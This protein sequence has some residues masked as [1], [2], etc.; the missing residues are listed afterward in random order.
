VTFSITVCAIWAIVWTLA[1]VEHTRLVRELAHQVATAPEADATWALRQMAQLQEPPLENIVLA[2]ASPTRDV[3]RQAQDSLTELLHKWQH[4]SKSGRGAARV[5]RRLERLAI[6]LDAE[7]IALTQMDPQWFERTLETMLRLAGP[8]S[9]ADNGLAFTEQCESMLLAARST[10]A[11]PRS[12]VVPVA[13]AILQSAP[14]G[15]FAPPSRLALQTIVPTDGPA[16]LEEDDAPPAPP[17]FSPDASPMPRPFRHESGGSLDPPEPMPAA[18]APQEDRALSEPL[19]AADSRA[20]LEAWLNAKGPSQLEIERELHRRGFGHLRSDVVRV[21]LDSQNSA[22][23]V[24][25]V[26]DLPTIPAIGA[27]AWLMLLAADPDAEVRRMVVSVMATSN[28]PELIDRAWNAA[29]RDSDSRVAAMA[30]QL[31]ERRTIAGT[32]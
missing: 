7:Q 22:E 12:E 11:G 3:A 32:R 13:S 27:K 10:N 28:D 4:E 25:L 2:A 31:R 16:V 1:R 18:A 8:A 26:V 23:R 24:Q 5:A 21:A 6:S 14:A 15:L 30:E 9:P 20:L 29:L 17:A 19:A